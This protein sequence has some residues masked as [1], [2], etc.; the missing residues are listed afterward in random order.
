VSAPAT[1]APARR[2]FLD[3]LGLHRPELRAWAMY[4]WGISAMQTVIMTAVFPIFYLKVP[5][6]E[7]GEQRALVW[8]GYINTAAAVVIAL[9]SP[10]LGAIAD[11][12]AAKKRFLATFMAI[13]VL[14]TIA[15]FFIQRGQIVYA[16][17][18]FILSLAASSG[19]MTF[20]ESL[21]PHIAKDDEIDRV[22]TAGYAFGYVGGGV[23][24]AVA[25][26]IIQF[27]GAFGLPSGEG[28]TPAQSSLPARIGF[29]LTGAWWLFFSLPV[30]RKVAEPPAGRE[31]SESERAS[32]IR[33]S[34]ARLGHTLRD[35]RRYKQAFLMM[36][37]FTIYNDGI[38]TII[39]MATVYGTELKIDSGT[40]I[41]A[42]LVVQFVGIPCAFL[43][44]MLAG[45]I[46]AKTSVYLGLL[47]YTGI[48]IYGYF[49]TSATDFWILAVAVGLVQGGTQALS[50]SMFASLVPR[51]KSGEF[52]GFFSVFEK[53]G[54][55]LGPLAFAVAADS[56]GSSRYAILSIIAFFA[57]GAWLL[58]KV[59]MAAGTAAARAADAETTPVPA[60]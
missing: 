36:V 20:Y 8:W 3:R 54:G 35:L 52:F 42:I 56:L 25:L 22:S 1:A 5:G 58:T 39:K 34:F 14:A 24:L 59:D 55:V 6:A 30:L 31:G 33:A 12:R 4:D 45:R 21:L 15:M 40:L 18:C 43:F 19:S 48:C 11:L 2:S 27:P 49:I 16:S 47:A 44:G 23:L 60:T 32:P 53:F 9:A 26:A 41:A 57:V 46:G 28:L 17:L 51:H 10:V 37:A 38:Q 29:L 50:R 7:V 13:G